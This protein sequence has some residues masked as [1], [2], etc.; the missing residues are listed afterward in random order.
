MTQEE[1]NKYWRKY[2]KQNAN[3][4]RLSYYIIVKAIK[5]SL[6]QVIQS[7][8]DRGLQ[9]TINEVE[10]VYRERTIKQAYENIYFEVGT[11]QKAWADVDRASR[12]PQNKA[13]CEL[14]TS[15]DGIYERR[16][17]EYN[18]GHFEGRS[19]KEEEDDRNNRFR[20]LPAQTQRGTFEVGFFNPAWLA[21][22][23]QIVNSVDVATR[24]TSVT[25]TIRK[26]IKQS[27][28]ESQQEFVSIRKITAK[29]RRDVGGLFSRQ[30]AETIARTEVTHIANIAAEQSAKETGLD[31]VKVWVRTLDSRT[32]DAHRNVTNK[33]IK[34]SEKFNVG[35]YY[36][37]YPGDPALPL[38]S[39][40][41]CRCVVA[42]FPA[43]DYEDLF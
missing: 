26:K 25:D 13:L 7:L 42:Y 1:Q 28:E 31:L 34:E 23:K 12:F 10:G 30:R 16:D 38:N 21:R 43:D 3:M 2:A 6:G 24:V 11:R 41:R 36:A 37:K 15:R 8:N 18:I 40:I 19:I 4:E 32:R 33:P 39:L 20:G 5:E 17:E 29:L 35:G 14:S 27:L 22:L 9:A